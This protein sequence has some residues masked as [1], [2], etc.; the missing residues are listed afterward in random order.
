MYILNI[1]E[2]QQQ[3]AEADK[4]AGVRGVLLVITLQ[5]LWVCLE[6]G[7]Q[8]HFM[9]EA[10]EEGRLIVEAGAALL[11]VAASLARSCKTSKTCGQAMD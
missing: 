1:V 3:Q 5:A 10:G 2:L 8:V 4:V 11:T 9:E 6:W 7:A